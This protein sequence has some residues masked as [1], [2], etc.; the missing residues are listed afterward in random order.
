M[1]ISNSD[2]NARLWNT[3]IGQ[4]FRLDETYKVVTAKMKMSGS[5]H[6][7]HM[8]LAFSYRSQQIKINKKYISV[9]P[10]ITTPL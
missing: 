10:K 4:Y 8:R 7:L 1:P 9:V 3:N 2:I 5:C 6:T